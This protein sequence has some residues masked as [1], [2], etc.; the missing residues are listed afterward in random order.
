M[1]AD[2]TEKSL[3]KRAALN[4]IMTALA[5]VFGYVEHLVP[6]PVGIYGLKLGIANLVVVIMLYTVNWKTALCINFARIF[7]SFLLFGSAT[8]LIYSLA[9]GVLSFIVMLFVKSL[10]KPSFSV[11]GVSLCGAVAHNA[12][13]MIAAAF[14][15]DEMRIAFY[16]P[17][18]VF[19]GAV[20]GTVIGLVANVVIKSPV[21]KKFT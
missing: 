12:G 10:K 1:A 11:V 16:L 4:G 17:V 3:A 18:L 15:L 13:Q 5:L 9:G 19:A 7:L 14:M 21:F 2:K 20:T 8:S 6:F